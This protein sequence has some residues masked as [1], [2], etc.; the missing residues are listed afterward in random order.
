[1][2]IWLN[3]RLVDSAIVEVSIDGWPEGEGIF[4]TIKTQG[5]EVF[6]LG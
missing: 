4:E 1:M 6:E 5:G 2:Q 3:N